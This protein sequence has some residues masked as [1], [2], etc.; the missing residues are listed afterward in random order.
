MNATQ[1]DELAVHFERALELPPDDRAKYIDD[2]G[3]VHPEQKEEL[4]GLLSAFGDASGFI[5]DLA[6]S[7]SP[8]HSA[9][10]KA[11]APP[12]KQSDLYD[13][14]G[15]RI[16][17]YLILD[18]LGGGG[19]GIVYRAEDTR[20]RRNVALK[21]LP[22]EWN[23]DEHA[24][25]R[26]MHEA[27]AASALDHANI[28]TVYEIGETEKHHLFIAMAYY[29]GMTLK[30]KMSTEEIGTQK[31]LNYILQIIRGLAR[32]HERQIIHRDIKPANIMITPDDEVKILDFGLAKMSDVQL[33]QTGATLGTFAFMSPEQARGEA[34]DART[35][36]WSLGVVM[37]E[38][39]SGQRPFSADYQPAL[40]YA[41]LHEEPT[42]FTPRDPD[43]PAELTDIVN[44]CLVKDRDKRVGSMSEL[45]QRLLPLYHGPDASG[46]RP[47][48]PVMTA[49]P[50]ARKNIKPR[51]VGLGI[52]LVLLIAVSLSPL[53]Q[54]VLSSMG[55]VPLP[56]KIHI[57][58][59]P[60]S[61]S[62]EIAESRPLA[63]GLVET[64][65]RQLGQLARRNAALWVVP[66]TDLTA[67]GVVDARDAER[68]FGANLALNGSFERSDRYQRITIRLLDTQTSKLL[69]SRVIEDNGNDLTEFQDIVLHDVVDMLGIDAT[70]LR[71]A[72]VAT[73][74][75]TVPGAYEFY[76][77]ASGLLQRYQDV[78]NIDAAITLFGQA[79]QSD[80][81]FAL[82][83][84]GLGEAYWRKYEADRDVRWSDLAIQ[85]CERAV[86]L[87]DQIPEVY[88]TLGLIH[89]GR[90][91]YGTAIA[92]FKLALSRDSLNADAYRALAKA[93]DEIGKL[94]EAEKEYRRAIA[95]KPD[96][97]AGYND[98]G[99]HY[100]R[101]GKYLEAVEQFES[102]IA[103]T[104]HNIR[105]YRNVGSIYFY[106]DRIPEAIDYFEQALAVAPDFS[107]YSNL[108]TAFFYQGEYTKSARTYEKALTLSDGSYDVW[109]YLGEAYF[110]IPEERSK[111]KNA[112]SRANQLARL[113]LKVNPRDLTL[114][115]DMA[116]NYVRIGKPDSSRILLERV[117][118][119][120]PTDLNVIY[121]IGFTYEQIGE[122]D[123]ALQ[124]I[125]RALDGG[126]SRV[127]IER[128]PGL[129]ML[130]RDPRYARFVTESTGQNQ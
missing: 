59:L 46:T 2:V 102:V 71:S 127:D 55:F 19:M 86:E 67:Q 80:P 111:A 125:K 18:K 7:L 112:F 105:G 60:F 97:W 93:Y 110:W 40:L 3:A 95:L 118:N 128:S 107:I 13:F 96:Y 66:T 88:V 109:G 42:P 87:D 101:N 9:L 124:W 37:F 116:N 5:R 47:A 62:G 8:V 77:Q 33:T 69:G 122:R 15:E 28:C 123:L 56:D 1:W 50:P 32:A 85:N 57:A 16:S 106:T 25:A 92:E 44:D 115:A 79:I 41:I 53:R 26:F 64:L 94:P 99:V 14:V 63:D 78:K 52:F 17:H 89:T 119:E 29:E 120:N 113:Q 84:A 82:A 104:P 4:Q 61:V 65:T 36:I 31:A 58:V 100:Y 81:T 20:L 70:S 10:N 129:R 108:A 72:E 121:T 39:L 43:S 35:D 68:F 11:T 91:R 51:I 114:L 117:I 45:Y 38:L 130:L 27:Q 12:D 90:G 22:P 34:V 103:L 76:L 21:F 24:K 23:R 83:F 49:A 73:R 126:Y 30:K 48:P 6:A 75:S 54:R 74:A 98:L